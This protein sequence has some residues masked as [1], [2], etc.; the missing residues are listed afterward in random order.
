MATEKVSLTLSARALAEARR[1]VGKRGLS[2]YI[3][4][5][6]QRKLQHDRLHALLDQMDA[7]VGPPSR[8]V[9]RRVEREWPKGK[10]RKPTKRGR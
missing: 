3:D 7:E 4:E 10:T 8:A 2:S 5:A 1:K 6:L 9:E